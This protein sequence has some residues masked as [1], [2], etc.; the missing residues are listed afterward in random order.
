MK[1]QIP[2]NLAQLKDLLEGAKINEIKKSDAHESICE[3]FV[4]K[5]KKKYSFTLFATD[6]GWG[7]SDV[8]RKDGEYKLFRELLDA[9]FEHYND[10]KDWESDSYEAFDNPMT[11]MIGFRC[12]KCSKEFQVT[13]T[14]LKSS[15][16]SEFL[17]T[18]EKREKFAKLLS[19]NYIQ[20]KDDVVRYL[21]DIEGK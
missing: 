18:P 5:D 19:G 8:K 10:H 11:R 13:M 15:E 21:S 12:K 6:L 4:E 3:M 1:S 17:T 14:D 2:E 9:T 20:E 16:Y 7:V